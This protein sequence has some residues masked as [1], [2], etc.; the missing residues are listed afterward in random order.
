MIYCFDATAFVPL[1]IH[2]SFSASALAQTRESPTGFVGPGLLFA[3]TTTV[4]RR[5]VHARVLEESRARQAVVRMFQTP[6]RLVHETTVYSRALDLAGRFA[7][8]KAYDT[9]YLATAELTDATLLTADK[10]M[11]EN[12]RTLGLRSRLLTPDS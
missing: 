2:T 1:L 9:I 6:I 8:S 4:L 5:H 11:H 7:Q 3:E 10:R 12:A